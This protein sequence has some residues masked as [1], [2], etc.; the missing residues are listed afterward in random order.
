MSPC[1]RLLVV[2]AQHCVIEES[3]SAKYPRTW[4]KNVQ[5][6][7]SA[8]IFGINKYGFAIYVYKLYHQCFSVEYGFFY[9]SGI[10]RSIQWSCR[11]GNEKTDCSRMRKKAH[12]LRH[13]NWFAHETMSEKQTKK[14]HT[15]DAWLTP[16]GTQQMFIR[17]G[18]APEVQPLTLL[19]IIF[20]ENRTP[21]VYLLLTNSTHFTY[22][23]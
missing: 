11:S 1:Y 2:L 10:H 13:H 23:V 15:D 4:T 7:N 8:A 14:F 17:A 19:Y 12:I 9:I 5:L 3:K 6:N 18:S 20:H 16:G 21:F 22:L